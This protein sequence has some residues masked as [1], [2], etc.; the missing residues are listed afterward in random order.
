MWTCEE[1]KHI[2]NVVFWRCFQRMNFRCLGGGSVTQYLLFCMRHVQTTILLAVYSYTIGRMVVPHSG[3]TAVL[4]FL[5]AG[6]RDG[7][8]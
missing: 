4:A 1:Q 7:I 6:V 5:N 8:I 3:K 2:Y